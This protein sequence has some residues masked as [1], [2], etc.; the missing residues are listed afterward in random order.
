[1][2]GRKLVKQEVL[3]LMGKIAGSLLI[4]YLILKIWIRFIGR[5]SIL[6]DRGIH[7]WINSRVPTGFWLVVAEMGIFGILPAWM[8]M[9]N[10]RNSYGWL[11]FACLLYCTGMVF[12]RFILTIVSLAMPVMPF[13]RF[14]T[15]WPS[16]QEWAP[17]FAILAYGGLMISL[18]YR[19][20]PIF[21]Q[22][23]ELN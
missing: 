5:F 19:Y 17:T 2:T 12:N 16:W 22:E 4:V 20:L 23:K 3:A 7:L 10:R 9:S 18:S 6:P 1:M 11:V 13:D 14:V 8:L 21:P 15:Y